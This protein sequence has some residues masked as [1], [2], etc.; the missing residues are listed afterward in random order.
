M[1]KQLR[2]AVCVM[3][4]VDGVDA[5]SRAVHTPMAW[6]DAEASCRNQ[7]GAL[8]SIATVPIS[9]DAC[10]LVQGYLAHEK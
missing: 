10:R 7:G 8:A 4:V 5:F 2:V 6:R 3:L 9:E 1:A